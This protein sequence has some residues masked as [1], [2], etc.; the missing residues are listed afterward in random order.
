LALGIIIFLTIV[1]LIIFYFTSIF[2]EKEFRT[3]M[4]EVNEHVVMISGKP[5]LNEMYIQ[6]HL[7]K[8]RKNVLVS[9]IA[10]ITVVTGG[11]VFIFY[12]IAGRSIKALS[13]V[14]KITTIE[15]PVYF[16]ENQIPNNEL[17]DSIR[18]RNEMVRDLNRAYHEGLFNK[19]STE[20]SRIS[21]ILSHEVLNPLMIIQG[22]VEVLEEKDDNKNELGSIR[23]NSERISEIINLL[24]S[25]SQVI[26]EREKK[27]ICLLNILSD[28]EKTK[29]FQMVTGEMKSCVVSIAYK[30]FRFGLELFTESNI[31]KNQNYKQ[32]SLIS[33]RKDHCAF[34]I[35][36]SDDFNYKEFERQYSKDFSAISD[37]SAG[38]GPTLY[39]AKVLFEMNKVKVNVISEGDVGIELAVRR[40]GGKPPA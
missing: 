21:N 34:K 16:H 39:M 15:N 13:K 35:S 11:V 28:L 20:I 33:N 40:A 24:D 10:I 27:D 25:F 1:E 2:R 4:K 17:G 9:V 32:I 5:Y 31:F 8:F 22:M 18:N 38:M 12:L 29:K 14:N 37:P 6:D 30:Q 3:L 26:T 7:K 19:M 23:K 36:F